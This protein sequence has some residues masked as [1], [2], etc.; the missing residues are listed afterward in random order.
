M[1]RTY[2]FAKSLY[3]KKQYKLANEIISAYLLKTAQAVFALKYKGHTG[4]KIIPIDPTTYKKTSPVGGS[5][6]ALF[7]T[8]EKRITL[9]DANIINV[10]EFVNVVSPQ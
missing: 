2:K 1:N 4:E 7:P 6:V 3:K 8:G 5:V 9:R 10:G